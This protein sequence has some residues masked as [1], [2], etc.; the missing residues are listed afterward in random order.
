MIKKIYLFILLL[1]F[2]SFQAKSQGIRFYWNNL[3]ESSN[4]LQGKLMGEN[5]YIS[6]L[7]NSNYFLQKDWVDATIELVDG[8]IFDNV[9]VRYLA[10]GDE[11][12]AYNDKIRSLYIVD[13]NIVKQFTIQAI[14]NNGDIKDQ[15]FIKLFYDRIAGGD[16]YFE[17]LYSGTRSLLAFHHIEEVKVSPFTDKMGVMR[18]SEFR[19]N[20]TYYIYSTNN[21]FLK[22]QKKKRSFM[23]ILPGHKKEIRKIFHQNKI[24]LLDEN[25]MVQA[26]TL[27][28]KADLF[29]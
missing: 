5:Y 12:I 29:N 14:S 17:E 8:D 23:K 9:K 28:D 25:S 27:L 20:V 6:S 24:I 26:F 18:D 22:L 3:N 19:L 4:R 2:F 16:R 13:K 21:I 10:F 11:L 7:A 15:K 1:A